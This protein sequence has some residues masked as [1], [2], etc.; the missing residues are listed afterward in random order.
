MAAGVTTPRVTWNSGTNSARIAII[1][2]S[3]LAA[4][5]FDQSMWGLIGNPTTATDGVAGALS[6]TLLAQP[7]M[8][9]GWAGAGTTRYGQASRFDSCRS[10]RKSCDL[11]VTTERCGCIDQASCEGSFR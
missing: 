3:G 5:A 6:T 9:L 1:T 7:A 4:S 8:V 2:V 10:P 11:C